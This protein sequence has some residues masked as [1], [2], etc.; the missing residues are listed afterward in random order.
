M[1]V[2]TLAEAKAH[3]NIT[4]STY[5]TELQ[6]FLNRAEA[7]LGQRIGPLASVAKTERVRGWCS[8]LRLSFTPVIS[9]TSV[10]S[11]EG[12]TIPTSQ[13]TTPPGGRV[14]YAQYG[15]FP[16]RWYDVVYQ[17]GRASLSDDLKL[18][19][20]ELVRRLWT[21]QRGGSRRPGSEEPPPG[22]GLMSAWV[23]QLAAPYRPVLG[24]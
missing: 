11:I 16:S 12:N 7:A 18:T 21:T 2:V 15:Y 4:V 10:T 1:S 22:D 9:L 17:A 24:A 3:L 20:L 5:D 8:V 19:V 14:E 13:L 23:D 6:D